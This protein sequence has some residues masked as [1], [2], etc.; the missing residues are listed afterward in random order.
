MW[1]RLGRGRGRG[2][3]REIKSITIDSCV[4]ETEGADWVGGRGGGVIRG[5]REWHQRMRQGKQRGR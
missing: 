4:R 3:E 2:P 5:D 1:G